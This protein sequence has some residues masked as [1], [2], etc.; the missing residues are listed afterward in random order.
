MKFHVIAGLPRAGSTLL[1]NVLNQNPKFFAS[2]TSILPVIVGNISNLLS[3]SPEYKSELHGRRKETE[4]KTVRAMKVFFE[5]W[6][7]DRKK[8]IIF[9]K[10]RAWGHHALA[11]KQIFPDGKIIVCVRDLR[12][13]YASVEKRHR[14]NPLLDYASNPDEKT[15]YQRASSMFSPQGLIGQPVQGIEDM[16]HRKMQNDIVVIQY[17]QFVENP[18]IVIERLY[19]SIGE[20]AYKHDFENIKSTAEDLDVLYNNKFPHEGF[21]NIKPTDNEEWKKY[22]SSDIANLIMNKFR[23]YN[24]VFGYK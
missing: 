20:K 21:G 3:N 15:L 1:C 9:D 10:S 19:D 18:K 2:S 13:I 5:E 22:I 8:Q 24:T 17:E 4:E 12:N 6:Y 7:K 23:Y 16:L 14:D 11:F